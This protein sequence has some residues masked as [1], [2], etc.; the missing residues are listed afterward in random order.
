MI[1]LSFIAIICFA[2]LIFWTFS[3]HLVL[4]HFVDAVPEEQ[5]KHLHPESQDEMIKNIAWM[6]FW[7][8]I[9]LVF[10]VGISS[11][12]IGSGFIRLGTDLLVYLAKTLK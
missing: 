2:L 12:S 8:D 7:K 6:M 4:R 11:L 10:M 3:E 5:Y 1:A 9:Y